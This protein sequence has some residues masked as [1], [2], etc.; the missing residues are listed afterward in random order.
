MLLCVTTQVV[1]TEVLKSKL[2]SFDHTVISAAALSLRS[3]CTVYCDTTHVSKQADC[4]LCDSLVI[5]ASFA[6]ESAVALELNLQ[7]DDS[8]L[9]LIQHRLPELCHVV[10]FCS[11]L[12]C[13]PQ[14]E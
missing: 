4:H 3:D 9:H 8:R 14:E 2:G 7:K 13:G 1:V 12:C 6:P 5:C 11:M 10:C